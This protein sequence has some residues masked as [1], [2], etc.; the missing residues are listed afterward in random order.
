MMLRGVEPSLIAIEYSVHH[1]RTF[2]LFSAGANNNVELAG[3]CRKHH[4]TSLSDTFEKFNLT[5]LNDVVSDVQSC[6]HLC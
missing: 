2:R 5:I 6:V 4:S 1:H 3:T